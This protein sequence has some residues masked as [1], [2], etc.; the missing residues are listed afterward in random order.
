MTVC[1]ILVARQLCEHTQFFILYS[2][3]LE[4]KILSTA[5]VM[6]R[7]VYLSIRL[8]LLLLSVHLYVS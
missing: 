8:H 4:P 5:F 2:V 6:L 7:V 3:K 1:V